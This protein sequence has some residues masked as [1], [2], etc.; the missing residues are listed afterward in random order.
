MTEL[1]KARREI[2]QADEEIAR[3]FERRM[4]AAAA[5]A[6]Y[7]KENG[8][9]VLDTGRERQI[10]NRVSLRTG[11]EWEHYAKLLYQTLFSVSRACQAE[12]LMEKTPLLTELERAA[13]SS[14]FRRE[15]R[16]S[17]LMAYIFS[18]R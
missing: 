12:R 5:V 7:K 8:L 15:S 9:P 13:A 11:P 4:R 6:A 2:D 16:C 17:S 14:S 3:A 18:S 1:E 10:I